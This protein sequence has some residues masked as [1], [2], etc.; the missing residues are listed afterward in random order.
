MPGFLTQYLAGM[1]TWEN[2]PDN[3]IRGVIRTNNHAFLIG[4]QGSDLFSFDLHALQKRGLSYKTASISFHNQEY[5]A[6]FNHMLDYLYQVSGKE[7]EVCTAYVAGF[8]CYYSMDQTASPYISYRAGENIGPDDKAKRAAAATQQVET[9]I[10]TVL[11]RSHCHMEPSQL[12]F[13][14]LTFASKKDLTAIGKLLRH[15]FWATYHRKIPQSEIANGLKNLRRKTVYLQPDARLR[16]ILT[17]AAAQT[18]LVLPTAVK[19]IYED[20]LPDEKDYM[21]TEGRPWYPYP[22][23]PSALHLTFEDIYRIAM[24]KS[25]DFLEGLDSCLSWGMNR[26]D[27]I[28]DILDYAPYER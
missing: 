24:R 19:T 14:A 26:D 7:L 21:N 15:A 2:L 12:N 28:R 4:L 5:G 6:L 17:H 1:E 11:L 25:A 23:C 16:R 9:I 3:Y 20:F 27:L 8:L 13:E 22:G 18:S 10:D